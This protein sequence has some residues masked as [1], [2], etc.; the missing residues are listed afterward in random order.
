[1]YDDD[2]IGECERT[3][4]G[5]ATIELLNELS[6]RVRADAPEEMY[7]MVY[8]TVADLAP[9][10]MAALTLG[11]VLGQLAIKYND[12]RMF[13]GA[14]SCMWFSGAMNA[15]PLMGE[16]PFEEM[17]DVADRIWEETQAE[18]TD[19]LSGKVDRLLDGM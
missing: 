9:H 14:I 5:E 2:E 19:I 11:Q 12:R 15:L 8:E 17:M 18:I 10:Q 3:V 13:Y 1:M 6:E 7:E 4:L 16:R